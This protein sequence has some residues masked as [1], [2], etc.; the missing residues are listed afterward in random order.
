M[1]DSQ[2]ITVQMVV[3]MQT[4]I[5]LRVYACADTSASP[6]EMLPWREQYRPR[7]AWDLLKSLTPTSF[8]GPFSVPPATPASSGVETAPPSSSQYSEEPQIR[9]ISDLFV[10]YCASFKIKNW[11]TALHAL[12]KAPATQ[13]RIQIYL[14]PYHTKENN[15]Y[16]WQELVASPAKKSLPL[17]AGFVISI[18][19]WS[20]NCCGPKNANAPECRGSSGLKSKQRLVEH[21]HSQRIMKPIP[22]EVVAIGVQSP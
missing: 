15:A 12:S 4:T 22:S 13:L 16:A 1:L 5:G 2:E 7:R 20:A 10:G 17:A 19:T 21:T 3:N 6:K 9:C 14:K 11:S 18:K 8:S